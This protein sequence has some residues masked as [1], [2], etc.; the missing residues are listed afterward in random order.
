MEEIAATALDQD[1]ANHNKN[2][3]R[4]YTS[5]FDCGNDT[6]S[7]KRS[8]PKIV[9]DQQLRNLRHEL[10]QNEMRG[11]FAFCQTCTHYWTNSEFTGC[12][13]MKG[14]GRI[15]SLQQFPESQERRLKAMAVEYQAGF[16]P[17]NPTV[18]NAAYNFHVHTKSCLKTLY[19]GTNGTEPERMFAYRNYI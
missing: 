15:H 4:K 1:F 2:G 17:V 18:V 11:A 7:K 6:C 13:V 3:K 12:R 19:P 14:P 5:C 16:K 9:T 8:L 10:G